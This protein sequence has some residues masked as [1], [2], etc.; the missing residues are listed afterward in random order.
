MAWG[1]GGGMWRFS[2]EESVYFPFIFWTLMALKRGALPPLGWETKGCCVA[3]GTASQDR[4]G[5]QGW[6]H[7][8]HRPANEPGT[9]GGEI[10]NPAPWPPCRAR[11]SAQARDRHV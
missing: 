2:C 11:G 8:G 5:I 6:N 1:G 7:A 9:S 4:K 3:A 10:P